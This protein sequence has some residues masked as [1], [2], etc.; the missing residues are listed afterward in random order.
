MSDPAGIFALTPVP[1]RFYPDISLKLASGPNYV[2]AAD[3]RFSRILSG[4]PD[5]NYLHGAVGH[6]LCIVRRPVT[7][8]GEKYG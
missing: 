6:K 1:D 8:Q 2:A 3:M 5:M 7:G 4:D